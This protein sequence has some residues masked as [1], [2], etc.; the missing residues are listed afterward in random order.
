MWFP[1]GSYVVYL[2]VYLVVP[3]VARKK[4]MPPEWLFMK[5][6]RRKG[7]IHCSMRISMVRSARNSG[8]ICPPQL[9]LASMCTPSEGKGW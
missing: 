8:G 3:L 9:S 7:R 1:C 6:R 4:P 5:N 2:V